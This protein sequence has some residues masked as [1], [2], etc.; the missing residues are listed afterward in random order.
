LEQRNL[1]DVVTRLEIAKDV[2]QYPTCF[3]LKLMSCVSHRPVSGGRDVSALCGT[4]WQGQ[5]AEDRV[6]GTVASD[7][8]ARLTPEIA[9][10]YRSGY[11]APLAL[12]LW[13]IPGARPCIP[14]GEASEADLRAELERAQLPALGER[15]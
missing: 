10:I 4:L 15:K 3:D 6:L 5:E 9:A 12:Q 7:G 1:A 8:K 14:L 11:R 13:M 2:F